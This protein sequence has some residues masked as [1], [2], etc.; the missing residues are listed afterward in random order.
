M[1]AF[2][3][4]VALESSGLQYW[5]PPVQS[6]AVYRVRAGMDD[7][8]WS[9]TSSNKSAAGYCLRAVIHNLG[10]NLAAVVANVWAL[11]IAD[12]NFHE[13]SRLICCLSAAR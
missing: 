10:M 7:G 1:D 9:A 3:E 11:L 13:V 5:E 2:G 12:Y 6:D 4:P 8:R